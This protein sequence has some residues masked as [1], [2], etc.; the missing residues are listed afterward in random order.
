VFPS[1][2]AVWLVAGCGLLV[3]GCCLLLSALLV[4][5]VACCL[6]VTGCG[7]LVAGLLFVAFAVEACSPFLVCLAGLLDRTFCLYKGACSLVIFSV[8]VL[9]RLFPCT[10][11]CVVLVLQAKLALVSLLYGPVACSGEAVP[12]HKPFVFLCSARSSCF[13]FPRAY[14][15]VVCNVLLDSSLYCKLVLLFLI[16]ILFT[17]DQKKKM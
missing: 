10:R 12:Q 11:L 2:L 5:P 9:G 8:L 6:V 17:F 16:Y 4:R 3:A 13:S 14:V 7:L 1:L 15:A